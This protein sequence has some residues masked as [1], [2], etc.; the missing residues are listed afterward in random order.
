MARAGWFVEPGRG[1]GTA[2]LAEVGEVL[3]AHPRARPRAEVGE[4]DI[5]GE[6]LS[7]GVFEDGGAGEALVEEVGAEG[8][9]GLAVVEEI[10]GAAVVDGEH[11]SGAPEREP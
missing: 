10:G 6:V 5:G 9:V 11:A 4:I 3:L 1:V 8:A 7:A 2:E